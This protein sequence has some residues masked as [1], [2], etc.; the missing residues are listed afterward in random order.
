MPLFRR[1][2]QYSFV[3]ISTFLLDLVIIFVLRELLGT[4]DL[5]AIGLGFLV[6]VSTNYYFN[7]HWVYKGTRQTIGRGYLIFFSLA[8][9][10]FAIIVFATLLLHS[11]TAVNLYVARIIIAAMVGITN[12]FLNTIFNFKMIH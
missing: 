12:F 7:Y 6:G 9:A 5:T 4:S 1:F 2:C 11:F 8:L 10:G 3:G